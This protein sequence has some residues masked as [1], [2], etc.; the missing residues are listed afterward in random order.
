[1]Q[2]SEFFINFRDGKD[3]FE[4]FGIIYTKLVVYHGQS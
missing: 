3:F 1:M 4:L 2:T